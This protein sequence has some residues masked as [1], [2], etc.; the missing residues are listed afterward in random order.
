MNLDS[1]GWM[2]VCD[3]SFLTSHTHGFAESKL[4]PDGF[5]YINVITAACTVVIALTPLVFESKACERHIHGL[6]FAA[7]AVNGVSSA[8]NHGGKQRGWAL[9]DDFTMVLVMV[10]LGLAADLLLLRLI[11]TPILRKCLRAIMLMVPT[12]VIT[13]F[14]VFAT[15][16]CHS[17]RFGSPLLYMV[18][19]FLLKTFAEVPTC[20][21][22]LRQRHVPG[23]WGQLALRRVGL[24]ALWSFVGVVAW[25]AAEYPYRTHGVPTLAW[26]HGVWHI[27]EAWA[28][29][30]AVQTLQGM[31]ALMDKDMTPEDF[32]RCATS[33]VPVSRCAADT[34]AHAGPEAGRGGGVELGTTNG[35][36][37]DEGHRL[38]GSH[39]RDR[40]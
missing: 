1:P 12:T 11:T 9:A 32:C 21:V 36:H 23:E 35:R 5:E 34:R 6:C 7:L 24:A 18:M 28:Y 25:V 39:D 38:L 30:A 27:S 20:V 22:L 15:T 37:A 26:L 2:P 19:F 33:L 29:T 17:G 4:W 16:K 8:V 40:P 3:T 10:L 31:E 14:S 13:L